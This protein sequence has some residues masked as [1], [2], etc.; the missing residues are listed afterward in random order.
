VTF[1]FVSLTSYCYF[2]I[3]RV[4]SIHSSIRGTVT[5]ECVMYGWSCWNLVTLV[6]MFWLCNSTCRE[7]SVHTSHFQICI[8]GDWKVM[9]MNHSIQ[10]TGQNYL[11]FFSKFNPLL[12]ILC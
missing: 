12:H 11:F 9:G 1:K 5:R 2:G 7:V 10:I 4:L 8:V 6:S 3:V